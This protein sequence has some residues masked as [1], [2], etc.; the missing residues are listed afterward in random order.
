MARVGER[1]REIRK[2]KRLSQE[3]LGK[4]IG[5][6]GSAITQYEKGKHQ[7]GA[8]ELPRIASA[9]GVSPC[10]FFEERTPAVA[11]RVYSA[12][13]RALAQE[14]LTIAEVPAPPA[15]QPTMH[16]MDTRAL[17]RTWQQLP[18]DQQEMLE[19]A[20]RELGRLKRGETQEEK[21]PQQ[22]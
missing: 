8:D 10:D 16:D 11:E 5:L 20:G 22:R 9:L 2:G 1:L 13:T 7:I 14:G 17:V 21:E 15:F 19:A 4:L 6:T 3:A 18:E 12:L